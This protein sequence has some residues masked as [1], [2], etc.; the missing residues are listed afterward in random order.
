LYAGT[1]AEFEKR[2][3][4]FKICFGET[5]DP[6]KYLEKAW[7]SHKELLILCWANQFLHLGSHVT[8][9]VEGAH[10]TLKNY[11][12]NSLGDLLVVKEKLLLQ[13]TSSCIKSENK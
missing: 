11:L 5:T 10:I 4:S 8:S 2:W 1:L 6:I 9:R 3:N 13:S 7:I 12:D